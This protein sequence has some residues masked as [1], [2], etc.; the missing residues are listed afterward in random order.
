MHV[1]FHLQQDS[2]GSMELLL[3]LE[4]AVGCGMCPT[5]SNMTKSDDEF[6]LC[7]SKFVVEHLIHQFQA[8]C[9][10]ILRDAEQS[11]MPLLSSA[12]RCLFRDG[13]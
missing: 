7:S 4:S 13:G 3:H 2:L 12:K 5:D 10:R 6:V 11:S 8:I 1:T 9:E